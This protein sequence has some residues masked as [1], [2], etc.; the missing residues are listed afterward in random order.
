MEAGPG[1]CEEEATD[2]P[3]LQKSSSVLLG[4]RRRW[5][6][7]SCNLDLQAQTTLRIQVPD[8]S[9]LRALSEGRGEGTVG[10]G[11]VA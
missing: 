1:K 8:L 7:I 4:L 2:L 10:S 3:T 5:V 9:Q 6:G 11:Y